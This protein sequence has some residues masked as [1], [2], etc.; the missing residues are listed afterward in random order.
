MRKL[1]KGMKRIKRF[2]TKAAAYAVAICLA[3]SGAPLTVL[4]AGVEGQTEQPAGNES[5]GGQGQ[6][7]GDESQN[8]GGGQTDQGGGSGAETGSGETDGGSGS[9]NPDSQDSTG[10]KDPDGDKTEEGGSGE[11][12]DPGD[13]DPSGSGTEEGG[14]GNDGESTGQDDKD[15]TGGE[16]EEGTGGNGGE[17]TGKDD[18]NP[19]G[20]GTEEGGSGNDGENT[21]PGDKDPEGSGTTDPGD[22]DPEGGGNTD[23]DGQDP[24]GDG[25][26]EGDGGE[27]A[28]PDSQE[29]TD[30]GVTDE[31]N[32]EENADG[33]QKDENVPDKDLI[34][35]AQ[36]NEILTPEVPLEPELIQPAL[37]TAASLPKEVPD[38]EMEPLVIADEDDHMA[39]DLHDYGNRYDV[40]GIVGSDT[41][42]SS[43]SG[44][45]IALKGEDYLSFDDE[46]K[47]TTENL[48]ISL[49]AKIIQIEGI[50]YVRMIY[51]V[52]NTS[53]D[54]S[55]EFSFGT[56]ADTCVGRD[57]SAL[58][59]RKDDGVLML[60][61]DTF[62]MD[63]DYL[64]A[65]SVRDDDE[66]DVPVDR[67]WFGRH[68]EEY[69]KVFPTDKDEELLDEISGVDSAMAFS[70]LDQELDAGETLKYSVLFGIGTVEDYGGDDKPEEPA[71]DDPDQPDQPVPPVVNDHKDS[72]SDDDHDD[73]QYWS[74][75][76]GKWSFGRNG[77]SYRDEWG[78]LYYNGSYNWYFFDQDGTMETGWV[79]APDGQKYYLNTASDGKQGAMCT[80][81]KLIDGKW[82]Y[83]NQEQGASQGRLLVGTTTP[84]G[85]KVDENGVWQPN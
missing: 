39:Y 53:V 27:N 83:F 16:S 75:T 85:Y 4:A 71:P 34:D 13:K 60:G 74:N 77:S 59:K 54:K 5:N 1:H 3:A 42:K 40:S 17:N 20:G 82:Y 56:Y 48:E 49:R 41:I 78:Y 31:G 50:S 47:A 58:V 23:P 26:A 81:W 33:D 8:T 67:W 29:P 65:F 61:R 63:Q 28:D 51:Y 25:T 18:E 15:P 76:D 70:W 43:F 22:K 36:K 14:N 68:G 24:S 79:T 46:R 66:S 2:K 72:D 32:Q 35:E 30:G 84:D 69:N 37:L 52:T 7:T 9:T 73:T 19:S 38:V 44:Y 57:D 10:D 64:Y 55:V 6:N 45:S 62:S 12:T 80:G 11:S 21:D